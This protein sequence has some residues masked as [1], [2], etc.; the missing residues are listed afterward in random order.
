MCVHFLYEIYLLLYEMP[1]HFFPNRVF[2]ITFPIFRSSP[3]FEVG[4]PV[5]LAI[6]CFAC[7]MPS[8]RFHEK[9]RPGMGVDLFVIVRKSRLRYFV[10]C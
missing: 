2:R 10:V 6:L 7:V 3:A 4:M 1:N 9:L 8:A 5:S